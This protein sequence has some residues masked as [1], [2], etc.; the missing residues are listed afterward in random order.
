NQNVFAELLT[1]RHVEL[2]KSKLDLLDANP[3]HYLQRTYRSNLDSSSLVN[4]E[5]TGKNDHR[6]SACNLCQWPRS[7]SVSACG[8]IPLCFSKQCQEI[9]LMKTQFHPYFH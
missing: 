4:F 9:G 5:T 8:F 1:P 6:R 2:T 3:I 7:R